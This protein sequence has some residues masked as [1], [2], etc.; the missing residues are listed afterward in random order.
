MPIRVS[1]QCGAAFQAKDELAGKRVRCPKCGQPLAI[2]A[3][4]KKPAAPAPLEDLLEDAHVE[5]AAV[6][7]CPECNA[8]LK[9][10]AVLCVECG[11]D[12]A[13]GR[14]LKT[15]RSEGDDDPEFANLPKHGNEMLDW[16]EREIIRNKLQQQR[17]ERGAPW[18]V[19][20][21]GVLFCGGFVF[22]A[23]RYKP[24][25]LVMAGVTLGSFAAF[26]VT[27]L[28][29][30]LSANFYSSLEKKYSQR[31]KAKDELVAPP[32]GYAM[33]III[34]FLGAQVVI[35][36]GLAPLFGLR[37]WEGFRGKEDLP[38]SWVF[39]ALVGLTS[40][41][42][43]VVVSA[44]MIPLKFKRSILFVLFFLLILGSVGGVGYLG[45]WLMFG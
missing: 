2:P 29:Y 44:T 10:G 24:N 22:Y 16:A 8:E 38:D 33:A 36:A 28:V 30:T 35:T 1:C 45:Y 3:P 6:P 31:L 26:F 34:A 15:Y 39:Y 5:E 21:L 9:P 17:M 12:L 7:R 4:A 41:I 19:F 14:K 11:F 37:W 20:L 13:A 43:L 27:A 32:L 18:W 25:S 42:T 40:Y 23:V